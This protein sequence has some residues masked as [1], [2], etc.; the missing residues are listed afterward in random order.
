MARIKLHQNVMK[1]AIVYTQHGL[2]NIGNSFGLCTKFE[3]I[4]NFSLRL[5]RQN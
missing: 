3:K 2:E 1:A 5:F 4:L